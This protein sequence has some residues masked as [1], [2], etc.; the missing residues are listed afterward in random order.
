MPNFK[1]PVTGVPSKQ[2]TF[3]NHTAIEDKHNAYFIPC[4]G[5]KECTQR[6]MLL[7]YMQ[8]TYW[9]PAPPDFETTVVIS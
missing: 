4:G 5:H 2:N 9:P 6:G 3:H 7:L 8:T 1:S